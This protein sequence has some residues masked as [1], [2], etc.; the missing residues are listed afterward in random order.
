MTK[1]SF[2]VK[3]VHISDGW[4]ENNGV[5]VTARM[6]AAEQRAAGHDVAAMRWASPRELRAADEV[7]IH[8]GW[9]PCLWWAS[10]W[11]RR[12]I[13][14]PHGC[15]DPIRLAYHGWKKRLAGPVERWCLRRA[16][17]IEALCEA[18]AV[19]IRG[20]EPRAK[21]VAVNDIRRFFKLGRKPR[22]IP[23]DRPLHLLFLGRRHPLKGV[24]FLEE[25]VRG[26][27]GCELRIESAVF[28]EGKKAL[29][30]WC[31]ALVLP[32]LSENFGLVVAEALEQGR[33]V[34]T[35]DG[36]PAWKGQPGVV[37][38]EGYREGSREQ[39]VRLLRDAI[40]GLCGKRG[41]SV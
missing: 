40:A 11:A 21:R 36:A 19:W 6:F 7:W 38:L 8:C 33:R 30:A 9:M 39:R 2:E 28:G 5:A 34:V 17:S 4:Q 41:G 15:Y 22:A 25:A 37:F 32:T 1:G 24:E 10:L 23:E 3:I 12:A 27:D 18:E 16:A 31:D 35:T 29:W 14:V 26:I 20:Y 13:R